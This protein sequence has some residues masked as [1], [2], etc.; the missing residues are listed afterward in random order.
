MLDVLWIVKPCGATYMANM[1]GKAAK[2]NTLIESINA[3]DD[4]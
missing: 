2:I 4:R 3:F 1:D